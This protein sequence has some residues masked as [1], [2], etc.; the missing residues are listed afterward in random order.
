[1]Y[2]NH[3]RSTIE[4]DYHAYFQTITNGFVD[5]VGLKRNATPTCEGIGVMDRVCV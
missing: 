1:M 3:S 5:R 4:E 2:V